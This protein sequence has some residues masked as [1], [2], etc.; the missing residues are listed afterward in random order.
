[1]IDWSRVSELRNEVGPEDF[2]EI[3]ELFLEEV[4]E[5]VDQLRALN[6][7]SQLQEM[8][9][10][11][12]GSALSLGFQSFAEFCQEGETE[13]A[14]GTAEKVN[15]EAIINQFDQSRARFLADLPS[16]VPG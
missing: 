4:D 5:M 14:S 12:K 15:L 2:D 7:R 9:H 11:L 6:D 10:F 16:C 13:S 8:L 3:L 1:M